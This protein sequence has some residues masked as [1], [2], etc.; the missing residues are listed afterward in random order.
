MGRP[1]ARLQSCHNS[2]GFSLQNRHFENKQILCLFIHLHSDY[3]IVLVDSVM[4]N[5]LR[6][7]FPFFFQ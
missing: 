4:F 2:E 6:T 1:T 7:T 3:I 5:V